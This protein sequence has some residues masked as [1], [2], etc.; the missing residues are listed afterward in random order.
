[1]SPSSPISAAAVDRENPW[2]G[3]A[4]FT[5]DLRGFFFGRE[6]ETEELVRLVRRQA[7]TVLFGQSGL[8]KSSLLQA[9]VF[10]RLRENDF[11]PLY[12]RLNH[13]PDSPSL[14]EQVKSALTAAFT[15]ARAE[16]PEFRASETLWEYF[17]RND[18]AIWSTKN[19]LLTPVLALDQFEEIF[20]LG[21]A[22]DTRRARG[23]AF[24]RELADLVEN[25]APAALRTRFDAGELDPSRYN[26]DKP[27]CQVVLTLREDFLPDL[28]GLKTEMR[29]ILTNRL[30]IRRLTGIQALEIVTKP[31]PRLLAEGV[32]ERVVEFVAGARGGSAERLAEMEVEPALLS[33]ICRE[34]N[35]RR[36]ALGQSQI[37]V[38]LVTGNRRE[39]LTDF[40]ESSVA[41]LPADMRAFVEDHLLTKSGFRDN[42][43]LETALE[44]PGVSRDL[45]DTLVSRRLLRIEEHLGVPRVELAHDVLAEVVRASRD[46]RQQRLALKEARRHTRMLQGLAAGLVLLLAGASWIAWHAVQA[47]RAEAAQASRTDFMIGSKLLEAGKTP[48][49]LAYLVRAGRTDS[50]NH[51]VAT[52]LM[53][54]LAF[55]NFALPVGEPLEHDANVEWAEYSKDGKRCLSLQGHSVFYYWDLEQRKLLRKIDIGSP[56]IAWDWDS[57]SRRVASSSPAGLVQIWDLESG[58]ILVGPLQGGPETRHLKLKF[59]PDGR[60]LAAG[61]ARIWDS[62]TGELKASVPGD[63]RHIHFAFSPDSNRILTRG[64]SGASCVWTIPDGNPVTPVMRTTPVTQFNTS[65]AFRP[66]GDLLSIRDSPTSMRFYDAATGAAV[67]PRLEHDQWIYSSAFSLDGTKFATVA[68]DQSARIWEVPSGKSLVPHLEHGE[69]L[70]YVCFT[71]DSRFL[72]TTTRRPTTRLWDASTGAMALE[73]MAVHFPGPVPNSPDLVTANGKLVSRWQT[74][75]S[76]VMPV[77]FPSA[78]ESKFVH[79]RPGMPTVWAVL[80]DRLQEMEA[81]TGRA[82]GAPRLFPVSAT[83]HVL[84]PDARYLLV[85]L[86]GSEEQELWD[87]RGSGIV[88]RPLGRYTLHH[89]EFTPDSKLITLVYAAGKSIRTWSTDPAKP[90]G[91]EFN[92]ESAENGLAA[93]PDGRLM[94]A[95]CM[96]GHVAV[97]D[98]HTLQTV[99]EPLRYDQSMRRVAFSPNGRLLAA[100]GYATIVQILSAT[101]LQQI[102][103]T[104]ELGDV[105][106]GLLFTRDGRRLLTKTPWA[107]RL[108]DSTTGAPLTEPMEQPLISKDPLAGTRLNEDDTLVVTWTEKGEL[109]IWDTASGLMVVGPIRLGASIRSV[110]FYSSDRFVTA[111][112]R[113]GSYAVCPLP[114]C[115]PKTSTPDWLL[116]QAE[117]LAGGTIDSF[118]FFRAQLSNVR[119]FREIRHKLAAAPDDAPFVEWGRWFLADRATRPVG[120]GMKITAAEAKVMAAPDPLVDL[121]TRETALKDQGK[122]A[123]AE[124][125]NREM[126][127]IAVTRGADDLSGLVMQQLRLAETLVMVNKFEEAERLARAS[128]AFREKQNGTESEIAW[129]RATLGSALVG[130][131]RY[132]EAEPLLVPACETLKRLLGNRSSAGGGLKLRVSWLIQLYDATGRPEQAE[133]WKR[134][135]AT[136]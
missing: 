63:S 94:A 69:P 41:D 119:A 88:R 111:T 105:V 19:R 85:S 107:I 31:A 53:S 91:G 46:E 90:L 127:A 113:N 10:P 72:V 13:S 38:D 39:I 23:A 135:L 59:S 64:N 1:M 56:S 95:A 78:A 71:P 93:S 124:P 67:S 82:M 66:G 17:H 2:P 47:R 79:W 51:V 108:W 9:G 112:L 122:F 81:F 61:G 136:L 129:A 5:E 118:A 45:I 110:A 100:G 44:T 55:R 11:L 98:M 114:P 49:G 123:E 83:P 57:D 74:S 35:E 32:A 14:A 87:L 102:G 99:G 18:V 27:S 37:T 36:R 133:E 30:R 70:R 92:L 34:L 3:L 40:Y 22:D 15:A 128:L 77:R 29:S 132:T 52:R 25:S 20:T 126:L 89:A 106:E 84:S 104:L 58:R 16:A 130:L 4:S 101:S 121:R 80:A 26:F 60:W 12:L 120:P 131:N 6:K 68:M 28:E 50:T 96:G 48:E 21:R 42:F 125:L 33:V 115:R 116:R 97:W 43:A 76:A 54:E 24:L 75:P 8:G 86:A 103:S 65:G 109:R 134:D 73:S 62:F 7:L 117:A